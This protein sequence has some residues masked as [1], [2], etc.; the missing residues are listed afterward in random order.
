M[1]PSPSSTHGRP[2]HW[3]THIFPT[4][5]GPVLEPSATEPHRHTGS[6]RLA[7]RLEPICVQAAAGTRPASLGGV[8][9][10]CQ[11]VL[12]P[13]STWGISDGLGLAGVLCGNG[14]LAHIWAQREQ[15]SAMSTLNAPCAA[16]L[17]GKQR[18]AALSEL[19]RAWRLRPRPPSLH[20]P[21]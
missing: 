7:G 4:Q 13:P 10:V 1:S 19:W 6:L 12:G 14:L 18:G 21:Q 9:T 5:P 2:R 3:V 11:E 15:W 20:G 17:A 16:P 8:P